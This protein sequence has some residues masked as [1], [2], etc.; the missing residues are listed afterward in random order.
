MAPGTE[1][2]F[3]RDLTLDAVPNSS[4]NILAAGEIWFRGGMISDTMLLA[5]PK[6]Q[7]A[8]IG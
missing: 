1:R 7:K 8:G 3:T 6:V 5:L 4:A 2:R